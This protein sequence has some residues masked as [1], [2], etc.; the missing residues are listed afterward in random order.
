[1]GEKDLMKK[2]VHFRFYSSLNDF[3]SPGNRQKMIEYLF[4]GHPTVKDAIQALGVPHT[5]VAFLLVNSDP[6][7]F[8]H[9]LKLRD[10]ISVYPVFKTLEVEE[11]SLLPM[12]QF[13]ALKFV[14]D[15]HLGK[16][17]RYLRMLG[18]DALY[19]DQFQDKELMK[20]SKEENRTILTRDL[21]I[22]M[23]NSVVHGYYV[24]SQVPPEQLKEVVQRFHL[25][26]HITAF[27][28]C[29]DCNGKLEGVTKEKVKDRL[30]AQT[31]QAFEDFYQCRQCFKIY[32]K[33]SHYER[34]ERMISEAIK[35]NS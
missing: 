5:E 6:V 9:H 19:D 8:S 22:L 3:L 15:G 25:A 7:D 29:M 18:F 34:M 4:W 27:T 21:G 32:W 10:Y 17:A 33:G 31:E 2:T 20:I 13:D 11:S 23:H 14:V 28:R 35:E 16:L 26:P 30:Q 1:M 24:R 12:L